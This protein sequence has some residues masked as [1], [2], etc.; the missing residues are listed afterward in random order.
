MNQVKKSVLLVEDEIALQEAVKLK[1]EK[2]GLEVWP[3]ATGEEALTLLSQK[4]PT[5][6]WLDILLPTMNGLELLRKFRENPSL[7]DLP[8]IVVSVSAGPEKIKQAFSLNVI[9]YLIK[10]DFTIDQII[11][12]VED[13]I[14]NLK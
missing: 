4:K 13:I 9:D 5:L 3:T 14:K 10:S 12:K 1:L 2:R 7:K 8:V 11:Q 6:V